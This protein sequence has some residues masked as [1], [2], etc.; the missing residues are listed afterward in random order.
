MCLPCCSISTSTSASKCV[1]TQR[2]LVCALDQSV[3][4]AYLFSNSL[5]ELCGVKPTER[6]SPVFEEDG[7]RLLPLSLDVRKEPKVFH[8]SKTT[9]FIRPQN[10][11]VIS[12]PSQVHH[13]VMHPRVSNRVFKL[14]STTKKSQKIGNIPHNR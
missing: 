6:H 5:M 2:L 1:F 13:H 11:H 3:Q 9:A 14:P 12:C 10:G 4:S 7:L 8:F